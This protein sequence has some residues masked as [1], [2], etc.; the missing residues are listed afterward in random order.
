MAIRSD[1]LTSNLTGRAENFLR[2]RQASAALVETLETEDYVV[3]S[4]PSV[5]PTKWHL[6]HTTWFFERFIL[7]PHASGY[8]VFDDRYHFLFNSYYYSQG[9]MH[10]RDRRGLLSR[11]TVSEILAY[12][13]YVDRQIAELLSN[14]YSRDVELLVTLG[15]NHEQQHQELML[16]DIKHVLSCNPLQPALTHAP[17]NTRTKSLPPLEF[18]RY[19]GGLIDIGT[20]SATFCFDNESPRHKVHLIPFR[21]ADRP[22]TN[23]EYREFIVDGGYEASSLWLSDGWAWVK[24]EAIDRP[25]YW[26]PDLSAEFTLSGMR[27]VDPAAPVTHISFYEADAFARWAGARL[28]TEAEW[29]LA[30]TE[31][32]FEG[33]FVEEGFLHPQPMPDAAQSLGAPSQLAQ[34]FGDT[35]EWTV[36]SYSPYPGFKP[37]DGSIG[38]YNGK[39]M[40]NQFVCRGGSCATAKD[41]IRDT[42]RNFFYPQ[43][44]WQFF[45]LRLAQDD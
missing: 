44:R 37:L 40:C 33:N 41:H 36:S 30:A 29:E 31:A 28:P 2:V 14:N 25:L 20:D 8:K 35:W 23:G 18:L 43:D 16:T 15:I 45:G 32:P 27:D 34:I 38:E 12:R 42:Y 10:S 1:D 26:S 17:Q 7:G 9:D 19:P 6:A 24:T 13:S 21:L 4:M 22:V 3:Q 5:S 11:P 39:F